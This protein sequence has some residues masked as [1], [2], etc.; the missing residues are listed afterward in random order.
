LKEGI[1]KARQTLVHVGDLPKKP[2]IRDKIESLNLQKVGCEGGQLGVI[3]L[4]RFVVPYG[5][6][7]YQPQHV[8]LHLE[9]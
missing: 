1:P 7:A 6:E 3:R 2:T 9:E 5:M 8:L 4:G